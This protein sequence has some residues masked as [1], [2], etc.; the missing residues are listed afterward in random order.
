MLKKVLPLALAIALAPSLKA[1]DVNA[2]MLLHPPK[3]SWPGYHGDY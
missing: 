2:A 3:D 1:Q